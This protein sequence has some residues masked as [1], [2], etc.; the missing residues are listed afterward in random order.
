MLWR[1]HHGWTLS[2]GGKVK[3]NW[4]QD[5]INEV[6]RNQLQFLMMITFIIN[7]VT[8]IGGAVMQTT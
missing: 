6:I 1:L 5:E 7:Y 8:K 2:E 3:T 4:K